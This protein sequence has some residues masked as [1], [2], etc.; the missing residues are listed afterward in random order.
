MRPI[1]SRLRASISPMRR[2]GIIQKFPFMHRSHTGFWRRIADGQR[3]PKATLF[4]KQIAGRL[5][6]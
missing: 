4:A 5:A 1:C 6:R 2:S 3:K